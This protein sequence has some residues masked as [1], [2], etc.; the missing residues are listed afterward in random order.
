MKQYLF[1]LLVLINSLHAEAQSAQLFIKNCETDEAIKDAYLFF[2]SKSSASWS[3]VGLTNND[4]II[5]I[6]NWKEI[7]RLSINHL[8]YISKE[9]SPSSTSHTEVCL[10]PA[11]IDLDEVVIKAKVSNPFIEIKGGKF[12]FE[13]ERISV[14]D[15]KIS[16]KEITIAEFEEF[17]NQTNYITEIEKLRLK[18][19]YFSGVAIDEP[20]QRIAKQTLKLFQKFREGNYKFNKEN[21]LPHITV[22]KFYRSKTDTLTWYHNDFGEDMRN[23]N[24]QFP[25]FR[26]TYKDAQAF[27]SWAG[28]RLPTKNEYLYLARKENSKRSWHSEISGGMV[29]ATGT[30][31]LSANKL[32]DIYGNVSE[33]IAPNSSNPFEVSVWVSDRYSSKFTEN[34]IN[35]HE[36]YIDLIDSPYFRADEE[37]IGFRIVKED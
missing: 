35:S 30:S 18:Q 28:G 16:Q 32:Y 33:Y 19:T 20:N 8:S 10:S 1:L 31:P 29:H 22:W 34:Y 37:F 21:E 25:V 27:A 4:G 15:F 3:Y 13:G 5:S 11:F 36:N 9:I 2:Q 17:V 12:K 24:P 23:I 6:P 14:K 26:I 7:G